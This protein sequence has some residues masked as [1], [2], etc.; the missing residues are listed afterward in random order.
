MT[1]EYIPFNN[2]FNP[3]PKFKQFLP[4]S[5]ILFYYIKIILFKIVQNRN[6]VSKI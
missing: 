4:S 3:E 2:H 1:I 6:L 5:F